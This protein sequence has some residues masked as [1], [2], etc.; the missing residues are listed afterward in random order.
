MGLLD[1]VEYFQPSAFRC[2]IFVTN[3]I[4]ISG[5]SFLI[6]LELS[7]EQRQER[8]GITM[9]ERRPPSKSAF[10]DH[11]GSGSTGNMSRR[12]VFFWMQRPF[13]SKEG[14]SVPFFLRQPGWL[15]H[16]AGE[17]VF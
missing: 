2:P 10:P 6:P 1:S 7:N 5:A 9:S 13:A 3:G 14:Y 8:P 12:T 4:E 11:D 16:F 15:R 17:L